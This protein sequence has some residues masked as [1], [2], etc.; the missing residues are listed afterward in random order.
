MIVV[1]WNNFNMDSISHFHEVLELEAWLNQ[2]ECIYTLTLAELNIVWRS[3]LHN[4]C[5]GRGNGVVCNC[6]SNFLLLFRVNAT[7]IIGIAFHSSHQCSVGQPLF[8]QE[9]QT[10]H[11]DYLYW[12]YFTV[13]IGGK[14]NK[15]RKGLSVF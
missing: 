2:G 3:I 11:L 13:D 15:W 7:V 1:P 10:T 12:L 5:R 9:Q 14:D 4:C 8:W 6:H